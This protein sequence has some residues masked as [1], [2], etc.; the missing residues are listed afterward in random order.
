MISS[1]PRVATRKIAARLPER[2]IAVI[3][4][5]CSYLEKIVILQNVASL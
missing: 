2:G 3:A 5:F 1:D 4:D